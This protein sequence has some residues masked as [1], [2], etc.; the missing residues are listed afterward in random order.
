MGILTQRVHRLTE[1]PKHSIAWQNNVF[2]FVLEK[3][4][5][6][7]GCKNPLVWV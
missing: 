3:L 5:E 2:L 1:R 4:G 7:I 6:Y